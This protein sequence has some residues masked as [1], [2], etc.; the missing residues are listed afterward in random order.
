MGSITSRDEWPP[1]PPKRFV[2]RWVE[3]I[4]N[5]ERTLVQVEDYVIDWPSLR[6]GGG[7]VRVEDDGGP[8]QQNAMRDLEGR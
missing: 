6:G 8:W 7:T 2:A 1:K 5:G 3:R 4:V